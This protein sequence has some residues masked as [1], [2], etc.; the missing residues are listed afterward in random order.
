MYDIFLL[1]DSMQ[2]IFSSQMIRPTD[3]LHPSAAPNFKTFQVLH[4]LPSEA[5]KIQHHKKLCSKCSILLVSALNLSP[6]S[7][8]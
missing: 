3:L 7:D 2:Y 8:T 5:S 4:D 1:R 6:L